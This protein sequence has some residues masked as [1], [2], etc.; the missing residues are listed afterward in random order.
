MSDSVEQLRTDL[1][2]AMWDAANVF[3]AHREEL[4]DLKPDFWAAIAGFQLAPASWSADQLIV[5]VTGSHRVLGAP[6]DFG[7]GT[8]CGD[9]LRRVYDLTNQLIDAQT[10]QAATAKVQT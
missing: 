10:Q 9:A 8:P 6:G 5:A 4:A 2:R 1:R 3:S 7:Y